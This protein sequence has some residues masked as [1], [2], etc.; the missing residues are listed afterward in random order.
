[1]TALG[2]SLASCSALRLS[3]AVVDGSAN[4]HYGLQYCQG[5]LSPWAKPDPSCS[6][7]SP[8]VL[9]LCCDG[10][11]VFPKTPWLGPAGHV[12]AYHTKIQKVKN[13]W[14]PGVPHGWKTSD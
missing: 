5:K 2:V 14:M 11:A 3:P 1:M 7:F 10:L 13:L 9:L 12:T 6:A 8:Y 4:W